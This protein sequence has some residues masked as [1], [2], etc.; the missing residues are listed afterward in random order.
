MLDL[1]LG[2]PR[3]AFDDGAMVQGTVDGEQVLLLKTSHGCFAVSATCPHHGAPLADG[4]LLDTSLRCPW[5]H[6]R[7]DVRSGAVTCPPAL[8]GLRRWRVEERNDLVY[9]REELKDVL[10]AP[11]TGMFATPVYTLINALTSVGAHVQRSSGVKSDPFV[12]IGAGAAG[13]S[14]ARTLRAEGFTGRLVMI[15]ADTDASVDRPNLS[16][17]VLAGTAP[18]EWLPL[19]DAAFYEQQKIERCLG[20]TVV[21]LDTSR[22]EIVLDDESTLRYDTV[23]LATGAASRHLHGVASPDVPVHYLRT[24]DD[25]HRLIGAAEHAKRV[26]IIGASFMGLEIAASLRQRGLDVHVVASDAIPFERILGAPIGEWL[27][28][29]HEQH[30]VVFHLGRRPVSITATEVVLD[31]DTRVP[32][33]LVVAAIGVSP[34]TELAE[35]AGLEVADGVVV[36]EYLQASHARVYAA[37]DVARWPMVATN[38]TA[39]IEHWVV[40]QRQG[41]VA[42]RNM[43]GRQVPY[44]APPFFWTTHYDTT[45]S[46]VGHAPAWD[47]ITIDGSLSAQ[48]ASVHFWRKNIIRATATINRDRDS[49]L[50]E[51]QMEWKTMQ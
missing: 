17:D 18:V 41:Q 25:C 1:R 39:R 30:G 21:R 40:A 50:A 10:S 13:T 27:T 49:L 47:A 7:F 24:L 2:V 19:R 28:D 43:M 29:I 42:A 22:R 4:L 14:A 46:Y 9:V 34:R 8:D 23:L 48:N 37:G 11:E 36:N 44:L 6:A 3:S 26:V 16:K 20:R 35:H 31:D 33:D 51:A 12:I 5:H 38:G 15:D 45:L 32:A